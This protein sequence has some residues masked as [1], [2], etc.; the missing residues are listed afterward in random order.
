MET[1]WPGFVCTSRAVVDSHR[2]RSG[3]FSIAE[4]FDHALAVRLFFG[5][6]RCGLLSSVER[7]DDALPIDPLGF[8]WIVSGTEQSQVLGCVCSALCVRFDMIELKAMCGPASL[9]TR[10]HVCATSFVSYKDLVTYRSGN[11]PGAFE[12]VFL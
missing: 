12:F 3:L 2:Y 8:Q 4:P 7:F 11:M 10:P 9:A 5:G 6:L 1:R